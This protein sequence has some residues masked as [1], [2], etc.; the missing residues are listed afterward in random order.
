MPAASAAA[1][2]EDD[3]SN[4]SAPHIIIYA[5]AAQGSLCIWLCGYGCN[6]TALT[7]DCSLLCS[8]SL[9]GCP[10][11][12]S[13]QSLA[14]TLPSP[15][16]LALLPPLL[17]LTY[18]LGAASPRHTPSMGTAALHLPHCLLLL[19]LLPAPSLQLNLLFSSTSSSAE[20]PP[21]PAPP[22]LVS[23]SFSPAPPAHLLLPLTSFIPLLHYLLC[24]FR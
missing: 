12:T 10:S 8:S 22:S 3:A 5:A 4:R 15:L 23:T 13:P 7:L 1:D 14:L 11:S 16:L 24:A 9:A 6:S 2:R 18:S 20:P 19:L 21:S 17:L